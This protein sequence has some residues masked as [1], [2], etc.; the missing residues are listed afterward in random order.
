MMEFLNSELYKRFI[1][2][3]IEKIEIDQI[4]LKPYLLK[5]KK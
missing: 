5:D 3:G 2:Y 1:E 4:V